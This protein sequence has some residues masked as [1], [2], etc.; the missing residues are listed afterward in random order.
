MKPSRRKALIALCTASLLV[1]L[2]AF[3]QQRSKPRRIGF[4]ATHASAAN[5]EWRTAF[6]NGM[7]ELGYLED[8]DYLIEYRFAA[9][10]GSRLQALAAELV[11]LGV[12]LIVAPTTA[13]ALAAH[14]KS[15][16]I[17]IVIVT[18]AVPIEAGLAAS[19]SRPGENVTGLTGLGGQLQ[20][21]RLELMRNILPQLQRVGD[22]NN[23][24]VLV[25]RLLVVEFKSGAQKLGITI[26][27]VVVRTG[28]D[29]DAAFVKLKQEDVHAVFVSPNVVN[30]SLRE[31]LIE[32]AAKHRIPA[33][34]GSTE[35]VEKGGL[36][37]YSANVIDQ[38]RRA[39]TYVVKIFKGA[40]PAEL[41]IEQPTKF[42]LVVNTRTAKALGL[43]IPQSILLRADR[44]IE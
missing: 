24:D 2:Q 11:A 22:V 44:V 15:R 17:P 28:S 4:L 43:A 35:F 9:G 10:D 27:P 41:P 26:V 42:E 25:D 7:R 34:Y 36:I 14:E 19:L 8:R 20:P 13:A 1:P 37:S 29:I 12:D 23:P 5:P 18:A 33:M 39:A 30:L 6:K 21:K 3:T 38:Y 31:R 40:N 32:H 16:K